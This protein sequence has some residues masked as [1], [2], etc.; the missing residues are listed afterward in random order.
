MDLA[1]GVEVGEQ[2]RPIA[3]VGLF[4]PSGKGS[5]PSVLVQIGTPAV[6]A[7][8]PE[9]TVVVP[10]VAGS[11]GRVDPAVLAVAAELGLWRVYRANGPA[12]VAALAFGT[13]SLP[14]H[15][16]VLGPGSPAVQAAMLEVQRH[17][18]VTH[19]VLGP[20]ESLIIAD[21][22]ADPALLAADLLNEAEH[23]PD[24][25][26]ILVTDS[27]ALVAATQAHLAAQLTQLPEPRASYARSSLGENGGAVIVRNIAEAA[28]VASRWAPEH[29][30]IATRDDEAVLGMIDHAGEVLLGQATPI[31]AA[32]YLIG[33][34]A[35]L[36]TGRFA[37]VSS[38]VTARTFMKTTSIARLSEQSLSQMADPICAL[39]D[40]EGFPAH[41]AAIRIRRER[42]DSTP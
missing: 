20:S 41:A 9:I 5:F 28:E 6:V 29:M 2:S 37:R 14:R 24:S 18:C 32:N 12:G 26:S 17:G 10:P 4:V 11:D 23:G 27:P 38:A 40:H 22:S 30:Q 34:P 31:S 19:M 8:V 33:V 16:K 36:P 42:V 7:G 3:S 21:N 39:A 35:A 25:S 13:A 1:P 15:D